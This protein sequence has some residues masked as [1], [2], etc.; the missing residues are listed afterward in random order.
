[1]KKRILNILFIVIFLLNS[2]TGKTSSQTPSNDVS[3]TCQHNYIA[4]KIESTCDSK[5]YTKYVCNKCNDTYSTNYTAE[6]GHNYIEQEKNYVCQR[7]GHNQTDGFSFTL[8]KN[9]NAY[10]YMISD[11]SSKAVVN[12]T[13]DIPQKYESLPILGINSAAFYKIG[14]SVEKIIIHDNIKLIN[15]HIFVKVTYWEV[16][17][18]KIPLKE[19]CF[20]NSCQGIRIY[21][22]AFSCCYNLEAIEMPSSGLVNNY[23]DSW[24]PTDT[25]YFQNNKIT[26]NGVSYIKDILAVTDQNQLSNE[27]I[28]KDGT[29][30]IGSNVF[31]QMTMIQSLTIPASVSYIGENA[32]NKCSQL[33]TI[34]YNG[35]IENFEKIIVNRGAFSEIKASQI[36]CTN[37]A[38]Q[39]ATIK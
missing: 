4:T 3:S 20:D 7:C 18:A 12:G 38:V 10:V 13:L 24:I 39:I 2:C 36:N 28:I 14:S 19:I 8:A 37:G 32:F 23:T 15:D 27:V 31:K 25:P 35:T 26:E 9:G 16:D 30:I 34:N 22:N 29:H 21:K 6:L 5:G 33:S 17:S 1:M 11:A